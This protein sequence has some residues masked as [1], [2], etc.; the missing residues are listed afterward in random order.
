MNDTE[1]FPDRNVHTADVLATAAALHRQTE[2]MDTMSLCQFAVELQ[3]SLRAAQGDSVRINNDPAF[4]LVVSELSERFR[5]GEFSEYDKHIAGNRKGL[6]DPGPLGQRS[7]WG[8]QAQEGA[9]NLTPL[10]RCLLEAGKQVQTELGTPE[11]DSAMWLIV[12]QMRHVAGAYGLT[13]DSDGTRQLVAWCEAQRAR[14]AVD[15][16]EHRSAILAP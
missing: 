14:L 4:R 12:H 16:I 10:T 1:C 6:E 13:R 8:D 9:S 5:C 3:Q 7:R 11:N 2:P 15:A